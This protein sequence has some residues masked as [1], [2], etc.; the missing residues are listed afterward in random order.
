MIVPQ[1]KAMSQRNDPF[2][3]SALRIV[4]IS[5]VIIAL[6]VFAFYLYVLLLSRLFQH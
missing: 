1:M 6:L 3:R 5:W 4:S 2:V